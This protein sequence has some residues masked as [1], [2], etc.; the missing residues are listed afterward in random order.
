MEYF[1]LVLFEANAAFSRPTHLGWCFLFF[2]MLRSMGVI[3]HE[4]VLFVSYYVRSAIWSIVAYTLVSY[5]T[6]PTN[7][8]VVGQ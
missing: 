5:H 1:F 3:Q 7:K 8:I 2:S 6:D 4:G